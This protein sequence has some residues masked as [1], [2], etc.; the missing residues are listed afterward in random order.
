VGH[1]LDPRSGRPAPDF[2]SATVFAA[3][4]AASDCRSTGLFVLGPERGAALAARWSRERQGEAVL[5]LVEPDGL[6]ALI[7]QGLAARARALAP[8]LRIETIAGFS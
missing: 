1:L 5:L 3:Q 6:R 8:D 7:T 2:G 4:A